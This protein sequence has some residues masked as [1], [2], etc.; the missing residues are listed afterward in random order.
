MG[1]KGL[2]LDMVMLDDIPP[3]PMQDTLSSTAVYDAIMKSRRTVLAW[4]QS[5]YTIFPVAERRPSGA[6]YVTLWIRRHF[7]GRSLP[8]VDEYRV[9]SSVMEGFGTELIDCIK[10]RKPFTLVYAADLIRKTALD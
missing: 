4:G 7:R 1:E 6:T 5:D 9:L 2:E 8:I 10:D 3:D